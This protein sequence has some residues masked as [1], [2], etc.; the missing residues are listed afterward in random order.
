VASAGEIPNRLFSSSDQ[1]VRRQRHWPR[2]LADL[3][4]QHI[5]PSCGRSCVVFESEK[6]V[7]PAKMAFPAE[8]VRSNEGLTEQ[9][10]LAQTDPYGSAWRVVLLPDDWN[11]AKAILTPGGD[12]AE[13]YLELMREANFAG[14]RSEC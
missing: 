9:P 10:S 6:F 12:V 13:P 4:D 7:G 1:A 5:Q 2:R 11:S 8:I 14:C 3:D